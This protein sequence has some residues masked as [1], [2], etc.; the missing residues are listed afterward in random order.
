MAV[1]ARLYAR[2][3]FE[4]AQETGR[5]G[6][7]HEELADFVHAM[8]EVPELGAL[9]RDPQLDSRAKSEALA[10]VLAGADE[11]VRNFVRVVV[12]KGRAAQLEE[13]EREFERLVA[14][15]EGRLDV[16]LTT[17][18]ELSD[19]EATDIVRQIEQAAGRTVEATRNV[20][21]DLIGGI[22][23]QAGTLRVDASVR[24]RLERLRHELVTRS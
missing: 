23:L 24:G 22:V 5:L 11:T 7:V 1:A 2:A 4:A 16:E 14:R 3:L 19:A 12:E 15:A 8:D 13:I 20:D 10:A 21:P 18:F 9:V 6:E 17:A